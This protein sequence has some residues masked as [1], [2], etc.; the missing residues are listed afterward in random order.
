MNPWI[1]SLASVLIVSLISFIGVLFIAFKKEKLQKI[2]FFLVSF[3]A[4]ALLGDVFLHLLPEAVEERGF[5]MPVSLIALGGILAFFIL[6]KFICWRHCHIPTSSEHPHP[7]ALMNLIGDGLHNFTDG[8]LIA[9]SYCCHPTLGISTT[10]AIIFHEIPQEIGDFGVLIHGGFS[11]Q[12]AMVLNFLSALLA[13]AGVLVAAILAARV[14][15]FT[16]AV[17]PFTAGGFVY[18]ATADLIP[19][20]KKETSLSKSFFQ[21]LGLLLGVG[22]M[23]LFTL[24][25]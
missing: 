10:L 15:G 23:W 1:Y 19:E 3:A 2:I 11:R 13:V 4:G 21:L 12:R 5:G 25:E 24:L 17:I 9:A 14:D 20:L 6:E 16:R 22:I 7:I 8:L 18:I